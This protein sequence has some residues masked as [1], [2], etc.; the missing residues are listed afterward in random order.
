ME[1][2][3]LSQARNI[4]RD[5]IA[6][7][8]ETKK[9]LKK[10]HLEKIRLNS[11]LENLSSNRHSE[12]AQ[13]NSAYCHPLDALLHDLQNRINNQASEENPVA[14]FSDNLSLRQ[15]IR[16]NLRKSWETRIGKDNFD[17]QQKLYGMNLEVE[18]RNEI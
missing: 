6:Q 2:E 16:N 7:T 12:T 18:V 4:L 9:N 13:Q 5:K 10:A 3:E 15:K 14:D 1:S 11:I 8:N 17:L